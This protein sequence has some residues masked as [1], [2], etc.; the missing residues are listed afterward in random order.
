M[1]WER[2]PN[3]KQTKN[4]AQYY[5][6]KNKQS[7]FSIAVNQQNEQNDENRKASVSTNNFEN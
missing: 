6:C 1:Q 3:I 2:Y 4:V 7:I 5:R